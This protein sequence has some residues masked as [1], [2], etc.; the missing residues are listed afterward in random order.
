MFGIDEQSIMAMSGVALYLAIFILPFFQE[1]VAVITA[2]TASVLGMGP[3]WLVFLVILLGLIASDIW[4][5]WIGYFGRRNSWAHRFA[6][7]PG[8]S[9]AGDLVRTELL[10]TLYVARFVPG[11]RVPTYV[12]CGFFKIHYGRFVLLVMLT[13]LTYVVISFSLFHTVGRVAGEQAKYWLPG[14]ALVLVGGYAIYRYIEHR[15]NRHGPM[16]PLTEARDHPMPDMPG[17]EG[18]PL[19]ESPPKRE[20]A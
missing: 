2:A 11:T 4:K 19:E 17:F 15:N 9:V 1:D 10:K 12:A 8:V 6:E 5:Y 7:K 3:V 16:T 14:I 20:S 13:A 18:N